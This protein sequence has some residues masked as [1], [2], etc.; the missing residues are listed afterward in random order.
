M[1][2]LCLILGSNYTAFL[3]VSAG[4]MMR[5]QGSLGLKRKRKGQLLPCG[6]DAIFFL[7][8]NLLI[9]HGIV[10]GHFCSVD[11]W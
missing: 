5:N 4:N 9:N 7:I 6:V 11:W 10:M 1:I 3:A 8:G 2:W